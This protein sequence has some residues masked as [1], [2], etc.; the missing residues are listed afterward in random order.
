MVLQTW[1][2][3]LLFLA[4]KSVE[5]YYFSLFPLHARQYLFTLPGFDLDCNAVV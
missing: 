4:A 2:F 1:R 3:P 5:F